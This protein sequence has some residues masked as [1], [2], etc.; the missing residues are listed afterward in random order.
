MAVEFNKSELDRMQSEAFRRVRD[1]QARAQQM[2]PGRDVQGQSVQHNSRQSANPQDQGGRYTSRTQSQAGTAQYGNQRYPQTNN[3]GYSQRGQTPRH[4]QSVP[5]SLPPRRGQ[6]AYDV[7]PTQREHDSQDQFHQSQRQPPSSGDN[8][9][10][11][12]ENRFEQQEYGHTQSS[13]HSSGGYSSSGQ[14]SANPFRQIQHNSR[15][16]PRPQES[17][18]MPQSTPSP[19]DRQHRP[20]PPAPPSDEKRPNSILNF[21]NFKGLD[22]DGDTSLIALLILLLSSDKNDELL[23]L[24]LIYIML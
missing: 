17:R 11:H 4:G 12:R 9:Y 3:S 23:M 24:A 21:L 14:Y 6:E 15:P 19:Q 16:I 20:Y 18:Y 22:L 13:E 2:N 8:Y 10:G 7:H 5:G 1:M